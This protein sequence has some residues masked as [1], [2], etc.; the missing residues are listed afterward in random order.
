ML[1]KCSGAE[2]GQRVVEADRPGG[3]ERGFGTR[4][5]DLVKSWWTQAP[6]PVRGQRGEY[7]CERDLSRKKML[8][9]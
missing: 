2:Q 4:D 9:S 8:G 5:S 1:S 7:R 3:R 6:R